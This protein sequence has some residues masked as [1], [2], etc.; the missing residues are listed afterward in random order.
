MS[1][2]TD[3]LLFVIQRR[4]ISYVQSKTTLSTYAIRQFRLGHIPKVSLDRFSIN[5]MYRVE[6]YRYSKLTGF[7]T[8]NAN[9]IKDWSMSRMLDYNKVYKGY[10]DEFAS[11]II[12]QKAMRDRAKG[13]F[14]DYDTYYQ[15]DIEWIKDNY[16]KNKKSIEEW[17]ENPYKSP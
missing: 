10:I 13:I 2:L 6:A 11:R 12:T 15:E 4:A 5:A 7:S 17:E 8:M 16:R 9:R 14:K 1:V 3:K